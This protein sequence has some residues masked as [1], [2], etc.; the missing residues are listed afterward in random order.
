MRACHE[1]QHAPMIGCEVRIGSVLELSK[2]K[3]TSVRYQMCYW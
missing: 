1:F 3:A 2:D